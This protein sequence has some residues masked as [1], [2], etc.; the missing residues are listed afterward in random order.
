MM[1]IPV[2]RRSLLFPI[3]LSLLSSEFLL[4]L[5]MFETL[6][7]LDRNLLLKINAMHT[8]FLDGMMW[9]MSK[10]WPTVLIIAATA[11]MFYRKYTLKK[12]IEFLVG[13]AI[14]FASTDLTTNLIKHAVKRYR[15]THNL[16]IKAQVHVVND[17]HGGQ[18][19]FYS[20]HAANTFSVITY[21]F[22]CIHWIKKNYRMVIFVYPI[23]VVYS[24][25]YLGVHYP[26]DIFIGTVS[27]L[28]FGWLGY[29]IMNKH[30]LKLDEQKS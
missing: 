5:G 30:F 4:L 28:F 1:G 13:C 12:A 15:P 10:S 18:Y 27:G 25:M 19:G 11:M 22:L 20:G 26:T 8:P 24:R 14:V 9:F 2:F 16:E 3:R 7:M 6:E 29:Y 17:Y 23:M 21:I